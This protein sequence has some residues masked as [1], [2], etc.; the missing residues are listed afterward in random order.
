MRKHKRIFIAY[1][2]SNC[3]YSL[4]RIAKQASGLHLFDKIILYTPD[5]LPTYIRKSPL[6]QYS[7]GGGYWAWKPCIINE[8]LKKFEEGD[9]VCYVDAG[10][11]LRNGIEWTLYFEFM[12]D[13]DMLCFKYRDEY[14]SWQKY[15]STSTQIKHWGK[16]NTLLFLDEW[17]GNK[18]WREENKIF[19]GLLFVKSKK[20]PIIRDWLKLTLQYPEIIIDPSEQELKNQYPFFALHK[21][22]Q[23]LL[24]ALT[25][26]YKQ[27]CLILPE[28]CE[29]CGRRVAI[30]ASRIRAKNKEQYLILR[31]KYWGRY[32]LGDKLFDYFKSLYK[33]IK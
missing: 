30:Y 4:S 3:T 1:G 16:K 27:N 18:Q 32:I 19:G 20:N 29:T 2:D 5:N 11:T 8:T 12:N 17:V 6:M 21:H 26:K 33:R 23:V 10:C 14:P 25:F 7:Y 22:D 24:V 31:L 28:T 15:G 13:Y 9:I